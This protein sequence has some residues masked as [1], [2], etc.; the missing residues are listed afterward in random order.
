MFVLSQ[1]MISERYL[2]VACDHDVTVELKDRKWVTGWAVKSDKQVFLCGL[3][4][5]YY[6]FKVWSAAYYL[7]LTSRMHVAEIVTLMELY[8]AE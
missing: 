6:S 8:S 3:V 1:C 4:L 5:Q 7:S 2:R